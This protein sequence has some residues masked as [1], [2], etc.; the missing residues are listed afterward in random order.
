MSDSPSM[1]LSETQ[2]DKF[3][4]SPPCPILRQT[5]RQTLQPILGTLR[6][7]FLARV[8]IFKTETPRP[9]RKAI[10]PTPRIGP[11]ATG[12]RKP[13]RW[14]CLLIFPATSA[15]RRRIGVRSAHAEPAVEFR[16]RHLPRFH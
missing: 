10:N 14:V 15:S 9:P 13:V 11:E 2:I 7:A 6:P 4:Q 12:S 16:S 3:C 1:T 8:A 5:A